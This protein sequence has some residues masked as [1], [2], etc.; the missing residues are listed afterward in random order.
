LPS[1]KF[2]ARTWFAIYAPAGVPRDTIEK[3]NGDVQHILAGASFKTA[4]LDPSMFEPMRGS[5]GEFAAVAEAD[6]QKWSDI[7]RDARVALD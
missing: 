3:I 7:I 4:F 2:N 1:P 6:M 5:P